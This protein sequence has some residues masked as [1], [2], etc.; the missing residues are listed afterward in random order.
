MNRRRFL[1]MLGA[2]PAALALPSLPA[3]AKAKSHGTTIVIQ[4]P[5]ND[6]RSDL[7][8]ATILSDVTGIV[9]G[10][11]GS[12]QLILRYSG[13]TILPLPPTPKPRTLA[14][15]ASARELAEAIIRVESAWLAMAFSA[16]GIE[17]AAATKALEALQRRV[18]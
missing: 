10:P 11:W 17:W 16:E 3:L 6:F 8:Y 15:R 12:D 2:I 13:E 7:Q 9:P 4:S 14:E 1:A 18:S 5:M